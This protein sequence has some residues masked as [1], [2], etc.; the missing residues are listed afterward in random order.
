MVHNL[1]VM[2][3][4]DGGGKV[5]PSVREAGGLEAGQNTQEGERDNQHRSCKFSLNHLKNMTKSPG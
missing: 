1:R 5:G 2:E 3:V 4:G